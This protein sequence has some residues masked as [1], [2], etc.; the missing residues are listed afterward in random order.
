MAETESTIQQLYTALARYPH[1]PFGWGTGK[2]NARTLGY[3]GR[4]LETLPGAVWESAAAVGN[5]FAVAAIAPGAVVL[6]L[7]CGAGADLCIA[8]TLVGPEGR[9]IGVDLTPAMVEKARASAALMHLVNVEVVHGDFANLPLDNE[10]VDV[11][12]SNGAIN[13]SEHKP[14]VFLETFRVLR[15]G[16]S[17][18]FADM[19]RTGEA[20]AEGSWAACVAGT[21]K[22]DRYVELLTSAGFRDARLVTLT[23]YKTAA[24][25]IGA[26]FSAAKPG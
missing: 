8:A 11:V 7:G 4:W 18:C 23:G 14:C 2:E 19:V 6:D 9:A 20:A 12:L 24:N 3:A 13:L 5:P 10:S 16:G 17:F 26:V 22:P 25:T 15:R 21:V 1:N